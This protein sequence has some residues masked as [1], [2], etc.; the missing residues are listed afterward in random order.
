M[1]I[2]DGGAIGAGTA[3]AVELLACAPHR[4]ERQAGRR[5]SGGSGPRSLLRGRHRR[6]LEA[7]GDPM[8]DA[9]PAELPGHGLL[10]QPRGVRLRLDSN[11]AGGVC[12]AAGLR[13]AG[14]PL[15]AYRRSPRG[16]GAPRGLSPHADGALRGELRRR[17]PAVGGR[18]R[19]A[20]PIQGYG[21]PPATVSSY[22]FADLFE[23]EGWG[24]RRSPRPGGPPRPRT[25]TVA[26][27]SSEVW[28]W[29][30]SPS[31][32][33]TPLDLKGEAHDHLLNG[34]NQL[35]GHGWPYSP[36]DA[37]GLGWFFYAPVRSTIATPGG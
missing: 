37:P 22:R 33:A 5:R 34:I 8:L 6:H 27:A 25:C 26:V 31:F 15:P 32:R 21:T 30:H 24:W 23:G 11:P 29:V 2:V 14:R 28:T 12:P 20:V 9:V 18:T 17:L 7:V 1:T 19:R 3:P 36:A 10:R 13:P 4:A 35:I 16:R